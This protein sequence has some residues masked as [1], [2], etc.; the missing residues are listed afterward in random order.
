LVG[1]NNCGKT[2]VLHAIR[3]F[4]LLMHGHVKFEGEPAAATYHRRFLSGAEEIAPT[5][6]IRELWHRQQVGSPITISITFDD[7]TKF[8]VVIRQQFGQVHV[9]AE[10]LPLGLT[11]ANVS[12]Y[13]G[14]QVAFIPGLVGVLVTEPYATGARRNALATQGRYS[15]I[16]RSSLQQLKIHSPDL[17]D[18]INVWLKDLFDITVSTVAFDGELDEFVTVKYSQND[19]EFD[20]VCSGAGLQQV[21]QMLTYLYL[22]KPRIL[23]VDEPDAHLHS[24]LQARLGE[25]FRRVASDLDA[26]VFLSTHS[27][28]LI[29]TFSTDDVLVVDSKKKTIAPIGRNADLVSVLVDANVVD[30]SALSRLLA[31]R[32]LVVIEDEDQT[33]LKSADKAIGSPLFSTQSS[34]FVLPAKGVGNFRAIAQ[35]GAVLKGLTGTSFELTFVQDRDG[36]P[37]FLVPSFLKAQTSDGIAAYLLE[38][39]E[40]ESYLLEPSLI[41]CAAGLLD[42]QMTAAAATKAIIAAADNLKAKARR[43]C[44]DTARLVSR[45]LPKGE[46]LGDVELEE[47]VYQWFDSQDLGSL[48]IVQRIFPGKEMIRETLRILNE[49]QKRPLTRGHLVASMSKATLA[50]DLIDLLRL[51]GGAAVKVASPMSAPALAGRARTPYRD[52]T[53]GARSKAPDKSPTAST[54]K[55]AIVPHIGGKRDQTGDLKLNENEARLLK[56]FADARGQLHI[57]AASKACF[58]DLDGEKAYSWARNSIRR[59]VQNGL[60]GQVDRGTYKVTAKGQAWN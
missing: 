47:R 22:S 46:H 42:R 26:Q 40:I 4:F 53:Q 37:D 6:D 13:L 25:L 14:T 5:P 12:A 56:C 30:V 23:L 27:L 31:S 39:H 24:K 28:D 34:S 20:V 48:P 45:H 7:D 11:A 41:E 29:D 51:V 16:F 36:M 8:S 35:L 49:G 38:R 54:M 33:I 59:L 43:T 50:P 57:R 10:E 17:V 19:S 21:I 52:G 58:P 3:A 1:P 32:R 2:T 15:E 9:S 60:V 18:T 55:S 44:L